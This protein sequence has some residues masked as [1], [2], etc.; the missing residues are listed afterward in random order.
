MIYLQNIH[1]FLKI[2]L[3]IMQNIVFCKKYNQLIIKLI[4]ATCKIFLILCDHHK[5]QLELFC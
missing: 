4:L 3:L 2:K 1:K 5:N